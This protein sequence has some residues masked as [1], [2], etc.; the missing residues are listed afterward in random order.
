M[1]DDSGAFTCTTGEVKVPGTRLLARYAVLGQYDFVLVAESDD[2]EAMAR[3]S[4]EL[5]ARARV[6][7]ETLTAISASLLPEPKDLV[8]GLESFSLGDPGGNLPSGPV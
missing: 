6:G 3:L 1:L 2:A 5:G 8:V 4:I 7:I